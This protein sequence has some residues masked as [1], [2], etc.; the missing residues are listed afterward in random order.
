MCLTQKYV[1][2]RI[3]QFAI[4]FAVTLQRVGAGESDLKQV[5]LQTMKC[6]KQGSERTVVPS[7]AV[8]NRHLLL[9]FHHK[10]R[11]LIFPL[12]NQLQLTF[13]YFFYLRLL[14]YW[15]QTVALTSGQKVCSSNF[16]S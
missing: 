2:E 13:K 3:L 15:A 7:V 14:M 1:E 9:F 16:S 10:C 4:P 6:L 12:P 5:A 8:G 11:C